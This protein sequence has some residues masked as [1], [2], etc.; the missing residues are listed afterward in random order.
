MDNLKPIVEALLFASE[1][2]LLF[3]RIKDVIGDKVSQANVRKCID[4]L[5]ALYR[6]N[7]HSFS[8]SE[9]AG[10][11][12]IR[13]L[14]EYHPYLKKLHEKRSEGIL[15]NAALETLS[16]IAYKQPITRAEIDSIR[17]VDSSAIV[18]GLM[19]KK[20]I[21]ITGRAEVPGRPLL[22][23]TSNNF[24]ELLGLSSLKDLPKIEEVQAG[25]PIGQPGRPAEA[26][27]ERAQTQAP[28]ADT[29][30]EAKEETTN[31]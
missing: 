28:K 4:E 19:E 29:T 20:L 7:G 13:T 17:G 14:P 10:G 16:I 25:L 2:P 15:S 1:K 9:V 30:V 23:G 21:R 6:S 27:A 31:I 3:S 12:Q 24:L 22:H 26:E 11:Y 5:N 8:I 18:R